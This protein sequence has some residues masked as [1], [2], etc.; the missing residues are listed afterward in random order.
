MTRWPVSAIDP[1]GGEAGGS[2]SADCEQDG[3]C[4]NRIH[5]SLPS[6]YHGWGSATANTPDG[7][8]PMRVAPRLRVTL[9]VLAVARVESGSGT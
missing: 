7:G 4:A 6:H 8:D 9:M 2:E 1:L 3:D 5:E